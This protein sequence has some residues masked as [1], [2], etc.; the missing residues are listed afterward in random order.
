MEE[1]WVDALDASSHED[2]QRALTHL[3]YVDKSFNRKRIRYHLLRGFVC[4]ALKN[5]AAAVENFEIAIKLLRVI[6]GFN[7]DE[8]NYILGYATIFGN[9]ALEA[10]NLTKDSKL[11]PQI[12]VASIDLSKVRQYFK[13]NFPLREHP[14]WDPSI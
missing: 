7:E 2:Y 10:G 6:D 4:F 14:N 3:D 8:K 12:D 11:F 1:H 5:N 13:L 9:K